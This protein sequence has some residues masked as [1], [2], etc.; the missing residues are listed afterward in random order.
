M[1]EL[2]ADQLA[3]AVPEEPE[4]DAGS[5]QQSWRRFRRNRIAVIGGIITLIVLLMALTA[6]LISIHDP[7]ETDAYHSL[8]GPSLSHPFGTDNVG[9]DV[10]ARVIYGARVSIQV[11]VLSVVVGI[12]LGV[13]LGA[14]AGYWS[15]TFLDEL[16]MRFFD[17]FIAF[18]TMILAI[19]VM[20]VLGVKPTAIGPIHI[21]SIG[22]IVIV[23]GVVFAPPFA[24]VIRSSFL[25]E[26]EEQY[27]QAAKSL[28]EGNARIIFTEILPN[29]VVPIIV[30]ATYYLAIAILIEASLSFLGVG[31]RPPTASWGSMLSDARG[32]IISGEWWFSVF[33]G[34][35]IL[36]TMAGLN[37]LGDGLRDALDPRTR[38]VGV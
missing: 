2:N 34:L 18:P 24:R 32:Y 5:F 20:G 7:D 10:M 22:K 8:T 35:A 19:A 28:G 17:I 15:G 11:G 36:L 25:Q 37:L 21:D 16:I 26:R 31:I 38:D 13:P 4:A 27:V 3:T 29:S 9:R 6:P 1:I 30:Q 23:T 12:L 14:I 33:P